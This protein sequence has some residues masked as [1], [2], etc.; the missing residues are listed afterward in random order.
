MK[1]F[2][3]LTLCF[4]TLSYTAQEP[5]TYPYNPDAN[6]DQFVAVSDVLET[7]AIYGSDY[8]P[9]EIMVGDTTLSNWIQILNQTLANQQAVIDSLQA[10]LDSQETQL[11]S[12]M[13]ADMIASAGGFGSGGCSFLYPDGLSNI[14]VVNHSFTY[15]GDYII[16]EGK[17]L[18]VHYFSG[19]EEGGTYGYVSA[20]NILITKVVNSSIYLDANAQQPFVFGTGQILAIDFAEQQP[21][22]IGF[23][24]ILVDKVSDPF[25]FNLSLDEEP[26]EVPENKMLVILNSITFGGDTEIYINDVKIGKLGQTTAYTNGMLPIVAT[27]GDVFSVSQNNDDFD[28]CNLIGYLVDE[29]YFADCGGVGNSEGE[30]INYLGFGEFEDITSLINDNLTNEGPYPEFQVEEDGFLYIFLNQPSNPNNPTWFQLTVDSVSNEDCFDCPPNYYG[31][32]GGTNYY[33]NSLGLAPIIIPIKKDH[34]WEFGGHPAT[35]IHQAWWIPLENEADGIS[36][37]GSGGVSVST[38]GDTLTVNG[39]S[40]IV[41][42]VSYLNVLPEFG[43]VT[44]ASGNTYP[45]I[46]YGLAGEWMTENLRTEQ[47]SNGDPITIYQE[48]SANLN[49][50]SCYDGHWLWPDNNYSFQAAYGKLYNGNAVNDERNVCPSGWHVPS[51]DDWIELFNFFSDNV[52]ST[53]NE[54]YKYRAV[55]NWNTNTATNESFMSLVPAGKANNGADVDGFGTYGYYWTSNFNTSGGVPFFSGTS[56]V[57]SIYDLI[58]QSSLTSYHFSSVRCIKD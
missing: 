56:L 52:Y 49:G 45:T 55:D 15:D 20:D 9:S 32:T 41:P 17:N 47:Y 5:L 57:F 46:D 26:Y 54:S 42:G 4:L 44:D 22:N 7:I 10:S 12:T 23:H 51:H 6:S 18:Y 36:E 50:Y 1:N 8:F 35:S 43:S 38:F 25:V 19:W 33:T 31:T 34:Y 3:T 28:Y 27:S 53:Y 58:E 29:D 39:E 14:E 48:C 2:F 37:G 24:G 30:V 21:F 40:V 16:P 11:D 13:I